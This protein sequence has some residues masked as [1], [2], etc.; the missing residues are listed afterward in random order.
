MR[1]IACCCPGGTNESAIT[2][3]PVWYPS[4]ESSGGSGRRVTVQSRI[5]IW[6][7]RARTYFASWL[8]R[9]VG[10]MHPSLAGGLHF[11]PALLSFLPHDVGGVLPRGLLL[12]DVEDR[13]LEDGA[14][15]GLEQRRGLLRR[16]LHRDGW[17]AP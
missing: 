12:G 7:A 6:F 5:P 11:F 17:L 15:V 9:W 10:V 14:R 4:S 8:R 13:G 3:K 2:P 16:G 1:R